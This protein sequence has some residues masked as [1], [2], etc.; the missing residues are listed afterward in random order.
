MLGIDQTA[1][2]QGDAATTMSFTHLRNTE[3]IK[4]NRRPGIEGEKT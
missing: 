1:Q 3:H 2:G 4:T